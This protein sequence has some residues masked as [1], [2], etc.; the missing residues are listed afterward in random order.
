[1]SYLNY[2]ILAFLFCIYGISAKIDDE[3]DYGGNAR[4]VNMADDDIMKI[5]QKWIDT[6]LSSLL[7]A[8]ANQKWV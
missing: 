6:G 3:N 2:L 8:V 5:Y 4:R 1:M 7:A